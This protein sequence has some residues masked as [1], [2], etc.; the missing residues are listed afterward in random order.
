MNNF[1]PKNTFQ[2]YE[3]ILFLYGSKNKRATT[4]MKRLLKDE[5]WRI[6]GLV[7]NIAPLLIGNSEDPKYGYLFRWYQNSL[8]KM[9]HNDLYNYC[10]HICKTFNTRV[11]PARSFVKVR[12][13]RPSLKIQKI[14]DDHKSRIY[15]EDLPF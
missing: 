12:K 3:S 2:L 15:E 4:Q 10:R 1:I 14:V 5:L 11:D 8:S 7:S 13:Y 6:N 9:D